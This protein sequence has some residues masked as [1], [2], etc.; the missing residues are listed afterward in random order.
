MFPDPYGWYVSIAHTC[1]YILRVVSNIFLLK[2]MRLV[3]HI[4]EQ[5]LLCPWSD[6]YL[7]LVIVTEKIYYSIPNVAIAYTL[8]SIACS[9]G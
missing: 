2:G 1:T 4:L 3:Q 5:L 8:I 6:I 9:I 7:D